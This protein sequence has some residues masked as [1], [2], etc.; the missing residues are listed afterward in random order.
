MRVLFISMPSI[1]AIRWIQNLEGSGYELYWFDILN[2]G[3]IDIYKE[4]HQF[5]GQVKRKLPVI[6]GEHFL[7][8]KMPKTYNLIRPILEVTENSAL[9]SIINS[10]KPDVIHSF[11]MQNCSYPILNTLARFSEIPWIYSCWGSDLFYYKNLYKH[12]KKIKKV[13]SRVDFLQT[14]CIRDC[15]IAKDLGFDGKC[16]PI[17]PG[18]SGYKIEELLHFKQ[19]FESRKIILVKGYQHNFGRALHVIKALE[20]NTEYFKDY[21]II[22]F[23]AH[24]NVINYINDH[25]LPFKVFDRNQLTNNEVLKLMG[26]ALIYVG[27]SVSD[28]MPNT[29]L[30]AIVMGAFPIQSNPGNATAEIIEDG[31]NGLLIQ[32]PEDVDNIASLILQA[33]RDLQMLKRAQDINEVISLER[34]EYETNKSRV[35]AIYSNIEKL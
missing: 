31:I 32:D 23:G 28:G 12:R 26:K 14:D 29:L 8:K 24:L 17:I 27:N 20:K 6:K 25:N 19:E 30:E 2:K 35:L 1:H 34:L 21:K 9:T 16:L 5:T 15:E 33:I 13:L 11:E 22:V 10:I 18:G 7:N 3:T 4:V